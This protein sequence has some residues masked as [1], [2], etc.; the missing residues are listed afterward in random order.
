MFGSDE[1]GEELLPIVIVMVT[2]LWV[3]IYP[4]AW[5][6]KQPCSLRNLISNKWSS[7]MSALISFRRTHCLL[8]VIQILPNSIAV[9]SH[10]QFSM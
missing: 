10:T 1:D 5:C 3:S 7:L 2:T 4:W 6:G 9:P 8:V